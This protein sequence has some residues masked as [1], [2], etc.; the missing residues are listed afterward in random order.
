MYCQINVQLDNAAF[1]DPGELPRMLRE[2]AGKLAGL[3]DL[4][5]G[6]W[7]LRDFNGNNVGRC[8]IK[9]KR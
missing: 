2:L 4:E 7:P 5:P 1:D 3:G 9:G 8:T 6:N